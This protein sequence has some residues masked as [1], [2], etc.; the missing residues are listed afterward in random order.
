MNY[1]VQGDTIATH[2]TNVFV[3]GPFFQLSSETL[4]QSCIICEFTI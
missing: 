1:K 2:V 4:T 3:P